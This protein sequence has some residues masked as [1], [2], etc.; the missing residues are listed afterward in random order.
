MKCVTVSVLYWV[1]AANNYTKNKKQIALH[2]VFA[3]EQLVD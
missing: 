2:T 3:Q 1:G